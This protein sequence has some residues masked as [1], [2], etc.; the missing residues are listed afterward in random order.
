MTRKNIKFSFTNNRGQQLSGLI[1]MPEAE[2]LFYGVFAPCF[3][4]TKESHAAHKV[5]RAFAE[6][7]I[8]M[9]RFDMTGLGQSEGDFAETSFSTRI[10]DITAACHA[11]AAAYQPP[12]ILIGHSISGTAALESVRHLPHIQVLATLGSPRDPVYILDKFKRNK[13]ITMKG[14]IAELVIA[15]RTVTV[16]KGFIDDMLIHDVAAATA[17][18]DRKLFVFHA[19]QDEIVSFE[20]ARTIF[21]RATCDKEFLPLSPYATH[22]LEQGAED[23]AFMAEVISDWLALHSK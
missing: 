12:A 21:D 2:P 14:D 19:P 13:Q 11:L 9:L 3:T 23:A 15:G 7:G 20:N 4:C 22:L 10:L 8:A 1:D 18:Y 5:C 17:A 6:R 16:K